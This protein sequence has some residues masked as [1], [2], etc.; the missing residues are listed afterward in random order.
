[1]KAL[2]DSLRIGTPSMNLS[3][4]IYQKYSAN[5]GGSHRPY[6]MNPPQSSFT[7]SLSL[8]PSSSDFNENEILDSESRKKSA[9][10]GSIWD[11]LNKDRSKKEVRTSNNAT[12]THC[13]D[14]S[15]IEQARSEYSPSDINRISHG[16][17]PSIASTASA[18]FKRLED[19]L[20]GLFDKLTSSFTRSHLQQSS[21]LTLD[22]DNNQ[23]RTG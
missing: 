10:M 12:T 4:D 21:F 9:N 13:S 18:R 2:P 7:P 22:F 16:R 20:K 19:H 3:N 11:I 23:N 8:S 6:R 1:M 15:E 5:S 17:T 14:P